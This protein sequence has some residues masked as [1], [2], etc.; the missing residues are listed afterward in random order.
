MGTGKT[1]VGKA[2]S[3]RLKLKFLDLDSLIEE[4]EGLKITDIFSQK[5][6]P[7]FRNAEKGIVKE[8]S[9]RSGLVVGCGGGVVL[10]KD[11]LDNLKKT[12]KVICL[13]ASPQVILKR[14][15]GRKQRPLLNVEDP[16]SKIEELLN[17]R[18]PLYAKA[19]Y[20]IDTSDL[21]IEEVIEE[22]LKFIQ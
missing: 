21:K 6:E 7:Y 2:L 17:L 14:T 16:E 5:G 9:Q 22:I 15:Q 1:A 10:D 4:K 12:G 3:K 13:T 19:D 18:A 20:Q 11:N 8:I